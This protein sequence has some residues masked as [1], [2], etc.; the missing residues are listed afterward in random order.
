VAW[1]AVKDR[2]DLDKQ[3]TE[4]TLGSRSAWAECK[5]IGR[6][7]PFG[8][9]WDYRCRLSLGTRRLPGGVLLVRVEER[10]I[11]AIQLPDGR[12]VRHG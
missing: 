10:R 1:N 3:A 2:N 7:W 11:T 4:V 5:S 12:V 9:D 6:L 8:R